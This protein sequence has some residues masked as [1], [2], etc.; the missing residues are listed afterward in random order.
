MDNT[1]RQS[2]HDEEDNDVYEDAQRL[3]PASRTMP[4]LCPAIEPRS[5]EGLTPGKES[6]HHPSRNISE[7]QLGARAMN[8][9]VLLVRPYWHCFALVSILSLIS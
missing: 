4:K 3:I 1:C 7:Q 5:A 9:T 8:V 6:V 2:V